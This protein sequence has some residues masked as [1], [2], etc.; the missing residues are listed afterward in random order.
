M[1]KKQPI[2]A[3]VKETTYKVKREKKQATEVGIERKVVPVEK[4][5]VLLLDQEWRK[6]PWEYRSG[7]KAAKWSRSRGE[8]SPYGVAELVRNSLVE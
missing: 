3:E 4:E 7:E 5:R 1:G 6:H 2:G 8:G